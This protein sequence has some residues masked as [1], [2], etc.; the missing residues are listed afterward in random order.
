M[1]SNCRFAGHISPSDR[2][3]LTAEIKLT[4]K[5][6]TVMYKTPNTDPSK[7][8]LLEFVS[9]FNEN[10]VYSTILVFASVHNCL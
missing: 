8:M 3:Q 4:D 7:T 10:N 1:V 5:N 9:Y 2:R 6:V